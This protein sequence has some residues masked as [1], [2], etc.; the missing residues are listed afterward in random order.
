MGLHGPTSIEPSSAGTSR[1]H[2]PRAA[3]SDLAGRMR[4]S[5]FHVEGYGELMEDWLQSRTKQ[6]NEERCPDAVPRGRE[7]F[8]EL[9]HVC[10]VTW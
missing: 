2:P 7:T 9:D 1:V 10:E 8:R 6:L 3:L 5:F 4:R